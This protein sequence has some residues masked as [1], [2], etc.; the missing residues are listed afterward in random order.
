[1][2]IVRPTHHVEWRVMTLRF[3]WTVGR[4][5]SDG[6]A[7]DEWIALT[8]TV[9]KHVQIVPLD[10]ALVAVNAA[11]LLQ[12]NDTD[13]EHKPKRCRVVWTK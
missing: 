6:P 9:K 11:L 13:I 12:S 1:M 8:E 10:G 7:P 5:Q 3:C 2:K 4:Y